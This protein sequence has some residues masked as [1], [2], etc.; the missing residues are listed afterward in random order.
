MATVI[1][2]NLVCQYIDKIVIKTIE[3]ESIFRIINGNKDLESLNVKTIENGH[4]TLH[5][6]LMVILLSAMAS[7][8]IFLQNNAF[9][10]TLPG[11]NGQIAFVSGRDRNWEVYIVNV[12]G[13]N[14]QHLANNV[15]TPFLGPDIYELDW[16][17]HRET[18]D[19]TSPVIKA[20]VN[21]T[22]G[23]SG[24]Y[25]SNV[26]HVS[27]NVTDPDSN[28]TSGYDGCNLVDI[29]SDT[30]GQ[31]LTCKATSAGGTSAESVII[32]KDSTP[33]TVASSQ[34]GEIFALNQQQQQNITPNFQCNDITS[35]IDNCTAKETKLDISTAGMHSYSVT[36]KDKAGNIATQ[37]ITYN[38]VKVWTIQGFLPALKNNG[39]SINVANAGKQIALQW[40]V[41]A[42]NKEL[43]DTHLFLNPS[44]D[45]RIA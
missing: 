33:P 7:A 44:Y 38:V 24:W 31:T 9:A 42:G 37:T 11:N 16:G 18:T 27:W 25:T 14:Q 1:S 8:Q 40:R 15:N 2:Y 35:G 13:T 12:D 43:T 6:L 28:V 22:K 17:T 19:I 20:N 21:G 30:T 5:I 39:T 23:N 36:A 32:K 34:Q 3:A 4:A 26:V 29:T 45:E 41:F 10:G